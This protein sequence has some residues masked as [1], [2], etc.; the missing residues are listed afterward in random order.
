MTG[1]KRPDYTHRPRGF[2]A[3]LVPVVA[4][5]A[6]EVYGVARDVEHTLSR[7]V[8]YLLGPEWEPRWLLVGWPLAALCLWLGPHFLFPHWVGG[9]ELA[10]LVA[11]A[12][13]F[14]VGVLLIR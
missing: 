3:W 14:A 5:V 9:R 10:A 7:T 8:W 1:R 12:F 13:T 6:Y 4:L 2:Y 11:L